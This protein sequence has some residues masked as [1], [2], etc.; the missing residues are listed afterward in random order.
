MYV[1]GGLAIML[2][3]GHIELIK[4]TTILLASNARSN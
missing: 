1:L 4:S 3:K 2:K